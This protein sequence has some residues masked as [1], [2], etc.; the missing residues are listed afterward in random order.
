MP[1][2]P[3][4]ILYLHAHDVGRYVQPYG[5]PVP[6]PALQSLAQDGMLFRQA[7]CANP[8]CSPSRACLL[9]GQY[10]HANGMM[11]LAHRGFRLNDYREHVVNL[12]K[13]G[14]GYHT[15]L[16]GTQH[17]ARPP[18]ANPDEIGYDELLT[19]EDDF[20]A[21][22]AAAEAFL[23]RKH[24]QPFFL[25]VGF[26]APHRDDDN[27]F[28][29]RFDP[30]NPNY[31]RPPA[32]LPDTAET[33]QDFAN[34]I[35]SMRSTDASMGRVLAALEAHGLAEDTLVIA[36][37]DH[38]IAFPAMKC[39]LSDHGIG[40]MLIL[41]GPGGFSG[42][43]VS[44]RLVSQIDIVPTILDLC[45][46]PIPAAVQGRSFL[47]DPTAAAPEE[48]IFAEVNFHAAEEPA[49]AIRTNRWKYIRRYRDYPHVVL[50]NCDDGLSKS[51]WMKSGWTDQPYESEMLF[52][53]LFD[54]N[55]CN[56]LADTPGCGRN[57]ALN[58]RSGCAP[59]VIP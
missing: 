25:S 24:D 28:P 2:K 38:G 1:K 56:N 26:F 47:A 30:P 53:L 36:T 48:R 34:Y 35:A 9:T 12:L 55:E 21:P 44:D 58:W 16:A 23:A 31:V 3:P 4:H 27:G 41:R 13:S 32:P 37:T 14:A 6:T 19:E 57:S 59:R 20:D 46:I 10:A 40:V 11:G 33:R 29:T 54:P 45:G 52:D 42:G 51:L 22:V 7:F 49:R 8:T 50:P 43:R 17:E 5:Y 39:S 15:A 18:G